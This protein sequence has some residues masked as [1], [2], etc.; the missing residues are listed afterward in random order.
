MCRSQ[1]DEAAAY[2]DIEFTKMCSAM[3]NE[4]DNEDLTQVDLMTRALIRLDDQVTTME[5]VCERQRSGTIGSEKRAEDYLFRGGLARWVLDLTVRVYWLTR[6][7]GPQIASI[8][9]AR[10]RRKKNKDDVT[11]PPDNLGS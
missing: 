9:I 6:E 8:K 10:D 1:E 4:L 3:V 7:V 2:Q 11:N 5:Q